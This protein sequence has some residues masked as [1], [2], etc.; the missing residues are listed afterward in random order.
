M[1]FHDV[2][3]ERFHGNARISAS[4]TIHDWWRGRSFPGGGVWRHGSTRRM[5]DFWLCRKRFN[6]C[7]FSWRRFFDTGSIWKAV[8]IFPIFIQLII[9]NV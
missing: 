8:A 9:R 7:R 1:F 4:G 6:W 2:R 5:V 3:L